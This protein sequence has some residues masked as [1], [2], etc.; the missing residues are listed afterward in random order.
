M[1]PASA[2]V[3]GRLRRMRSSRMQVAARPVSPAAEMRVNTPVPC[4]GG[5]ESSEKNVPVA[6]A[7]TTPATAKTRAI[8]TT[9]GPRS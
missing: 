9:V 8:V 1:V 5:W 2:A 4:G 3:L 6:K 7:M